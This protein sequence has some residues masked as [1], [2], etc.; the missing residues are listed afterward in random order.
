MLHFRR[1][2]ELASL[3][4]TFPVTVTADNRFVLYVN[5]VR[6]ASGPSTGTIA[7]WRYSS[8]D[9]A[10]H[11][12]RG[13]NVIA[14][15]VWNFG[16]AAPMA[17]VSL[18]TG[19]RLTGAGISTSEPG[20]R[21]AIDAGHTASKGSQQID[22]HATWPAR[23][24]PSKRRRLWEWEGAAKRAGWRDAVPAPEAAKRVLAADTC[25]RNSSRLAFRPAPW[26]VPISRTARDFHI[27][28]RPAHATRFLVRRDAVISATRCSTS[29][30]AARH[31]ARIWRSAVRRGAPQ[32][33]PIR[34][35]ARW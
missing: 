3:A 10:P 23:Q 7:R 30:A 28:L 27:G 35:S 21:V 20:W 9:L 24:R 31:H 17:Q 8:L 4:A 5:G 16:D 22:W 14:A 13:S 18:A 29:Q 12:H 32:G 2:L 1:T 33:R 25:R 6:V 34:T 15:V 19:F 26:C 11:L